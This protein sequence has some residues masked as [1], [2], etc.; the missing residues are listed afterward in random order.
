MQAKLLRRL[1]RA[2]ARAA[3]A[4]AAATKLAEAAAEK[5]ANSERTSRVNH[6][7]GA[8]TDE[9]CTKTV[10]VKRQNS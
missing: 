9:V 10:C 1:D 2:H 3:A 7:L 5:D 6:R 4:H 8:A